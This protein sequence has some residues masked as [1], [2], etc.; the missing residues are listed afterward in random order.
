M[1]PSLTGSE[2]VTCIG[3]LKLRFSGESAETDS[4]QMRVHASIEILVRARIEISM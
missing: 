1:Q 3:D 2:K 4:A